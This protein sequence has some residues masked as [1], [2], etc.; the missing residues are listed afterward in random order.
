[1]AQIFY[2]NGRRWKLLKRG[3][4]IPL[5]LAAAAVGL[6]SYAL[7]YP[8]N[9]TVASA[10]TRT[11]L[12]KSIEDINEH[13]RPVIDAG[14]FITID[15]TYGNVFVKRFGE[16][17]RRVILTFDD[18]PDPVYTPKIMEILK[19]NG[20]PATFFIVGKQ[21]DRYPDVVRDLIREGFD[22][23]LHTYSHRE[24]PEDVKLKATDFIREI[25]FTQKLF[26]YHFGYKTNLFRIPYQGLETLLSYNSLQYLR[27]ALARGYT[28]SGPT[29]D[30]VD[31]AARSPAEVYGR[32]IHPQVET[33]VVLMHDG[34]GN[35][36]YVIKA[37]PAIIAWYKSNNYRFTSVSEYARE[38]GLPVRS[39]LTSMDRVLIP[40][41]V[42]TY[43]VSTKWFPRAVSDSFLIGFFV[44]IAHGAFLLIFAIYQKIRTSRNRKTGCSPYRPFVSV[45]IPMFNEQ[46][47]IAKCVSSAFRSSYPKLEVIVA[48]DGS[49]DDS[50]RSL[51]RFFGKPGFSL[52]KLEHRG[53]HA[54]LNTAIAKSRGSIVVTVDADTRLTKSAVARIVRCFRD[55]SVGSVSG[56]VRVGNGKSLITR[57]QMIEYTLAQTLEKR[58]MD[59]TGT[60]TVTPGAFGAWRKWVLKRA[61]GFTGDTLA[62]D[63]DLTLR[64]IRR[65]YKSYFCDR[66]IAYTEVPDSV[67]DLVRQRLRWYYG[68][69]QV[70]AKHR[71]MILKK[72]YGDLGL[73][74]LPRMVLL[75]MGISLAVPFVDLAI[76]VNIAYGYYLMVLVFF[77]LYL[78][79]QKIIIDLSY[80]ME[81]RRRPSFLVVLA[82][83]FWY[84]QILS[85]ALYRSV[86]RA[87]QGQFTSW[88][89]IHHTGRL[90]VSW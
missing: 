13:S 55:T 22:I 29:V 73:L 27:E 9:H 3:F 71:D 56:N 70:L 23:G 1:M 42:G 68:N 18:G 83:R 85:W 31:W 26:A 38:Y 17:D 65:G 4:V 81:R 58:V 57:T 63:F 35:R 28:I 90:T 77:F 75:Q 10:E 20:V 69:L 37:L 19:T 8:P 53:K 45:V 12:D 15:P 72:Q 67:S 54:A 49:T 33:A 14:T 34:G 30:S 36:E 5:C 6:I 62:E 84:S 25:D 59:I 11:Y 46:A 21:F 74:F 41:A 32:A 89:K 40:I 64:I 2:D 7:L 78:L 76:L 52:L 60:V 88:H 79:F 43:D 66:A 82:S 86:L 44:V 87:L 48:D 47:V 50:V 80:S 16:Y 61:G 24:N 39:D 51:K